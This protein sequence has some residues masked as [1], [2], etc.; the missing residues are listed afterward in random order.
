MNEP[1]IQISKL[2]KH[3]GPHEVLRGIS[4]EVPEGSVVGLLG[5]NGS[6]KTTL[7]QCLVGLLRITSGSAKMFGED[8][9]DLSAET[10]ARLAYVPQQVQCYAWMNVRQ[11][12]EYTAA[13][14][15]NWDHEL[16]SQLV[17]QWELDESSRVSTLSTGQ[18]QR[19]GLVMAMGHQPEL[20]LLDEPAAS[21]DPQGRRELLKT[22]LE[23]NSDHSRTVLFSTHITSDLE[24][25]A[26]HVAILRNGVID[27]FGR[28]DDLK[29][30]VKRLRITG[31]E[32]LPT[33]FNIPR[34]LRTDI[35]GRTA[36]AAVAEL[37]SQLPDQLAAE[38]NV[39]VQVEDLNLEEI[40]LE[41]HHD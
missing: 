19:L 7:M 6:G 25:V 17:Q 3:F 12:I 5:V 37:D 30:T 11:M 38:W 4:L 35:S 28:L 31:A 26:S 34:A 40:F 10:K 24:R 15:S 41:L 23:N 18:Q 1:V 29:D 22:L 32:A 8:P 13:F 27:Y 14:Y 20:L 2:R 16:C 39:D 33:T 36:V 21:L 9:W